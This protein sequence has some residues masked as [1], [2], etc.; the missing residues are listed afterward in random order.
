MLQRVRALRPVRGLADF[1]NGRQ[2]EADQ[3]GDDRDGDEELDEGEGGAGYF[4][5]G[6]SGLRT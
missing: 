3:D 1:L 5:F 6:L 2:R 4:F